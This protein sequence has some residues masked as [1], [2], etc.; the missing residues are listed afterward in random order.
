V[1]LLTAIKTGATVVGSVANLLTQYPALSEVIDKLII[2]IQS[3]AGIP[4]IAG[5]TAEL[6]SSLSI[7]S[8]ALLNLLYML[9]GAL[10]LF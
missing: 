4:E 10:A 6:A 7:S 5:G 1:F 9:G 8:E 3:G 2:L